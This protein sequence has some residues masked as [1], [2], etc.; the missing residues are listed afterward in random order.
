MVQ[1]EEIDSG[2][3]SSKNLRRFLVP[4]SRRLTC[5]VLHFHQQVPLCPHHRLFHLAPL[6][7]LRKS[8]PNRIS[9]PVLFMKAYGILAQEVPVFRQTWMSFPWPSIYQHDESVG[10]L[11]IQREYRGEQWLFW[12]RFVHPERTPLADLQRQLDVYQTAPVKQTFKRFLRLSS[13]PNPLRRFIWWCNM[14][15]SGNTRSQRLGTFF[16]STLAGMTCLM[17]ASVGEILATAEMVRHPLT[18]IA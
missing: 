8:L 16:L 4:R 10:M 15:L 9:W 12:G 11:A 18:R 3:A 6:E 13:V 5:D 17:R 1:G 7:T 2:P 14:Q